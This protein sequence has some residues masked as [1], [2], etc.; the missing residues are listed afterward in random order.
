M[1]A[2]AIAEGFKRSVEIHGLKFNKLIGNIG[3]KFLES[4]TNKIKNTRRRKLFQ[5]HRTKKVASSGP[6]QYYGLVETLIKDITPEEIN[7]RKKTFLDSLS[8][9]PTNRLALEFETRVQSNSQM[10]HKERRNR[11]TAS[12]FGRICK[13]RTSTSCKNTVYDLLY[14]SFTSKATEYGKLME[15]V[16]IKEA[17]KKIGQVINT[18]GIFIDVNHGYLHRLAHGVLSLVDAANAVN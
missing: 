2:D 9:T 1:E 13:M 10:W 16:A 7:N 11:L 8:L 4:K 15:S 14:R 3:K 17:E 6:D 12:N 18:C 5:E